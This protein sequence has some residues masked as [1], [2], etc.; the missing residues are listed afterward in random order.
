MEEEMQL[1]L[2]LEI[3]R[4]L[5]LGM[6]AA[7]A[8][9][10]A[11]LAF[12]HRDTVREEHRQARGTRLA[13]EAITDFRYAARTLARAPGFVATAVITLAVAIAIG[14]LLFTAVNG[15]FYRPLPVPDGAGLIAVFT[16]DYDGRQRFGASSHADILRFA[17]G[18]A[19]AARIVGATR[20]MF[21]VGR[22]DHAAMAQ[23][24]IVTAGYFPLFGVQP[25]LGRFP[26]GPTEFPSVVLS[27]TL[28]RRTF[29]A[30]SGLIGQPILLNGHPFTVLAVSTPEFRGFSR[31]VADDFWIGTEFAPLVLARDD[32]LR[33]RTARRFRAVARLHDG[34]SLDALNARL[35]GVASQLVQ[36]DPDAWRDI[37]DNGRTITA[38]RERDAHLANIP[39]ADLLLV[40]GGV[41][42]LGLG[43]LGIACANLTSLQVA[44]GAARRREIATRLALGAGRARL[45]RQLLA[46]SALV[47]LP[48]VIAGVVI[49]VVVAGLVSHFRP[50]PLP[51]IDLSLDWRALAFIGGGLSLALVLLGLI[52]ALQTV[53]SDLLT[54]LK[55][56]S[57]PGA[58]GLKIGGV[59]G[60]LIIAQVAL[61]VLLSALSGT[62]AFAL[63]RHAD[64]GRD[65][66]QQVLVARINYL[67]AAGDSAGVRALTDDLVAA[68]ATLPG[69][70]AAGVAEFIPVRGT[71][72]TVSATTY[73]AGG[74]PR[75]VVLDANGVGPGYFAAV[76][77]T[78]VRGREF[79]PLDA[80]SIDPSVI[81]SRAMADALWPGEDPLGKRLTID[82]RRRAG[83][84][85]VVGVVA[86]PIGQ[87][88]ATPASFPGLLYLPIAYLEEGEAVL[89]ARVPT[90]Q[91]AVAAQVAQL[92]RRENRRLIAPEVIS[93]DVYHDRVL[94][95]QR[96][97][98]QAS[99]A[100]A[101]FQILLA[102][103]GLSGLVAY[104]TA[105]R[106]RELGIRVALGAS[107][108]SVLGLVMRQALLLT[109]VGCA[110]GLALGAL[111]GR[112]VAVTLPVTAGTLIAA[113]GA[114]LLGVAAT[115]TVAMLLP[116]RRALRV[117][118]AE[119]LRLD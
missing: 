8:R 11:L 46:E 75:P 29:A 23:G 74:E 28:W 102:V 45:I 56:G 119:V 81:V 66:A 41:G 55:G 89:H 15:F 26:D 68:L 106:R 100:L 57:Q 114:A 52:P 118:P 49:A 92:L 44:R 33:D 17:E 115:G 94:L 99:G 76:G 7:E 51:S 58:V 91:A 117:A 34:V 105:L 16:S 36:E 88:P 71:R 6:T 31:E 14:T 86:D 82:A 62:V 38:I 70:T 5:A 30:D 67:P 2:D 79:V 95:P 1:H 113:L 40:V 4:N 22:D 10:T 72:R 98:A 111:A 50:I 39:R 85:E 53:R 24:S 87:G 73:G 42:A 12:G 78:M 37:N 59:R 32:F 47:V 65:E 69:V 116:A 18:A 3:E 80:R 35:A 83:S 61:S 108:G 54:D 63:A 27:Y 104:V 103:A 93:L 112:V 101:L 107:Q 90:A 109:G 25:E 96:L 19:P 9:R 64:R 13:D 84:A 48:G 77:L 60:G 97:L 20:V 43:L 110:I 21:A